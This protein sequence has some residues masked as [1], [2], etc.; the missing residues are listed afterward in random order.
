[1]MK[2]DL[3]SDLLKTKLVNE[4]SYQLLKLNGITSVFDL[5]H[6]FPLRYEDYST[7]LTTNQI[8]QAGFFHIIAT[9]QSINTRR[10]FRRGIS[11]A[12]VTV[13]DDT[14]FFKFTFF[15]NRFIA[16]ILKK[17]QKYIFLCQAGITNYGLQVT[18]PLFYSYHRDIII[19]K[20]IPIY[21][22]TKSIKS[23]WFKLKISKIINSS[24][25]LPDYLPDHI[26]K[27]LKLLPLSEAIY[28]IHKPSNF[29]D[30]KLATKRISFN[31]I[32]LMQLRNFYRQT[33]Y[34]KQR[35]HQVK[36]DLSYLKKDLK[37]ISFDLTNYQ[38]K[39]LW[40]ILQDLDQKTPM[41]RLLEGDVG[42][43]K[44]VIAALAA[45]HNTNSKFQTVIVAP[46][47]ILALQHY[48]KFSDYLS[49]R[50]Y[51][52]GIFTQSTIQINQNKIN[53]EKFIRATGKGS[54]DIIIA[55]HAIWH[56][57]IKFKN[58]NLV[59]IDEQHRFGVKQRNLLSS[60]S[61][62]V[63]HTLTMSATPI[64]RSLALSVYGHIKISQIKSLP[65]GRKPIIT[66]IIHPNYR[67]Q[68]Y[69]FVN[70]EIKKGR[71]A[72]VICPL[73]E[74]SEKISVKSVTDEY[75][76][77]GKIF[78]KFKI[79]LLH[80]Q[81]KDKEKE[82]VMNQFNAG[83]ID[84]IVSTSVIEVG[85]DVPNANI[86]IIEGSERFGL[87]Q[88]HQFRGRVGRGEHQSY[89][90]LFTDLPN[91]KVI[92]RLRVLVKTNDG[93]KIAEADLKLRGPGDMSGFRQSG[94]PD[95]KMASLSDQ[96]LIELSLKSVKDLLKKDPVL[97]HH[98]NLLAKISS[99]SNFLN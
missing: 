27:E 85:I 6:Y 98:P 80:G 32:F 46:T 89:C 39:S 51:Q 93:F 43:G 37:N 31:E 83:K 87:S 45:S 4:K 10:S 21:S 38:K 12:E 68:T 63:P 28:K 75:K 30:I 5:L 90:F 99:T 56:N 54:I 77:L 94:L 2:I 26:I 49:H 55:T 48:Q 71:Q 73:V 17:E 81:L 52:I 67:Q 97:S 47:E 33:G 20:I 76:K 92:A 22:E 41:N 3:K 19:E 79:A 16:K 36:F 40:E 18:N 15:N 9:V 60:D 62:F 70:M 64:P 13:K 25:D 72:F 91:P 23:N 14:G 8:K 34:R 53:K 74:E 88:L 11:M 66:K 7:K 61:H 29:H 82:E 50:N 78:P 69:D 95:L 44:T 59:I 57:Q 24:H 96:K 86:I 35:S 42:S 1:M 58:L 84:I 65:Q